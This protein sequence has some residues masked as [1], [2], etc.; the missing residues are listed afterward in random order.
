ML[1]EGQIMMSFDILKG[2]WLL[3]ESI[4]ELKS[5]SMKSLWGVLLRLSYFRAWMWAWIWLVLKR[6]DDIRGYYAQ[7]TSV[8]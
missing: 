8:N 1:T 2:M 5:V 6:D 7:V 4:V 3:K